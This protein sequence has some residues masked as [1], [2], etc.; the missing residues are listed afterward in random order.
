MDFYE[1]QRHRTII[2][3][4]ACAGFLIFM[5][6]TYNMLSKLS[7]LAIIAWF[8][9][10]LLII[11]FV[12]FISLKTIIN[13]EG[14][15]VK[16]FPF[17][18]KHYSW[19][20]IEKVYVRKY[21]ALREYGGWGYKKVAFRFGIRI[22]NFKQYGKAITMSGNTGLQ[23]EFTNGSKLLIGTHKPEEM[24]EVLKKL[25]KFSNDNSI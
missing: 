15:Y 5:F 3:L 6:E 18:Y 4:L 23:L 12:Y 13:A 25:G 24:T 8:A 16:I 17:L 7:V 11:V 20:E 9:I 22:F 10:P 1:E 2:P 19:D 14:I 21:R